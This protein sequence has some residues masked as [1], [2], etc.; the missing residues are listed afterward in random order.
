MLADATQEQLEAQETQHP[1]SEGVHSDQPDEQSFVD[2]EMGRDESTKQN[3]ETG[4]KSQLPEEGKYRGKATRRMAEMA[5]VDMQTNPQ[6]EEDPWHVDAD[7]EG[8]NIPGSHV[9]LIKTNAFDRGSQDDQPTS[10]EFAVGEDGQDRPALE[11]M[12]VHLEEELAKWKAQT[13]S[14]LTSET[15]WRTFEARTSGLAQELS[16]QL[17]LILEATVASKLQGD[18]RSGKRISMRKVIPYI[19]S[20][21]RKDKIWLR[22]TKPSKREYQ[23]LLCIDD[24][25]SMRHTGAGK[26]ACEALAVLCQALSRVEVRPPPCT[27]IITNSC[28]D[29]RAIFWT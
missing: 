9:G 24:S 8:E 7:A 23:V 15:L 22:R 11:Q 21:F 19:A 28:A 4:E 10:K 27:S 26:L 12:Q 5:S 13:D 1:N 25:E 2:E 3:E 18:Y 20:G 16:E 29:R 14:A 6:E 17:R